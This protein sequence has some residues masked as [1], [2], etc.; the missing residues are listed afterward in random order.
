MCICCCLFN[1]H[2]WSCVFV[3]AYLIRMYDHVYLLLL[4]IALLTHMSDPCLS[5][6]QYSYIAIVQSN[7]FM[8]AADKPYISPTKA[9]Q[10]V[11]MTRWLLSKLNCS[12]P[13]SVGEN[14]S[15]L[16]RN[17]PY[18]S[19]CLSRVLSYFR[20]ANVIGSLL[21]WACCIS[22]YLPSTLQT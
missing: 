5:F 15:H 20:A 19:S 21:L 16:S 22:V 8:I 6:A 7:Y 10:A 4:I 2:V 17:K 18:L 3:A 13:D 1:T 11:S 12:H 14:Y 9:I